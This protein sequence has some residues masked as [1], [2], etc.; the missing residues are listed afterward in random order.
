MDTKASRV[1]ASHAV[2]K[3]I[4]ETVNRNPKFD[5]ISRSVARLAKR[6]R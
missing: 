6:S 3:G 4:R 5:Q 2:V 1:S